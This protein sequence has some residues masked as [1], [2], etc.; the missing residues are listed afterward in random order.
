M[1][2][3]AISDGEMLSVLQK[4][5]KIEESSGIFGNGSMSN[6]DQV[7]SVFSQIQKSAKSNPG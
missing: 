5:K 6:I 3:Q 4:M 7:I 1:N 2:G